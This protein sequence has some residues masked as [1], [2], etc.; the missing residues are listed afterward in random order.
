VEH[1]QEQSERKGKRTAISTYIRGFGITFF[2]VLYTVLWT[3]VDI[4]G[5]KKLGALQG[6]SFA[7]REG[8]S[9][10]LSETQAKPLKREGTYASA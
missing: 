10:A 8:T 9:R 6:R 2:L 1:Y 3:V 5:A 7:T 4:T